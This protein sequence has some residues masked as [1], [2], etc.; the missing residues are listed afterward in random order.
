MQNHAYNQ[1]FKEL[2][3]KFTQDLTHLI[4][5]LINYLNAKQASLSEYMEENKRRKRQ[6]Q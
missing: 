1:I 3:K 2:Y 4:E 5:K 6:R